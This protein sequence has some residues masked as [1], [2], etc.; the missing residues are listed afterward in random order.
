MSPKRE[1]MFSRR[2]ESLE[3]MW[4]TKLISLFEMVSRLKK[5]NQS[6]VRAEAYLSASWL[7]DKTSD[8]SLVIKRENVD[9]M[10]TPLEYGLQHCCMLHL[11]DYLKKYWCWSP[12]GCWFRHHWSFVGPEHM[13]FFLKLS[14]SLVCNSLRITNC[15]TRSSGQLNT[16]RWLLEKI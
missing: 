1:V 7:F 12:V 13:Y 6:P 15:Y 16:F 11:H 14:R 5:G 8:D 4:Q 3:R 9:G 2:S 10:E